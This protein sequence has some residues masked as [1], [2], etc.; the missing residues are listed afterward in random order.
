MEREG[1][2][3]FLE[4]KMRLSVFTDAVRDLSRLMSAIDLAALILQV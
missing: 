1:F 3:F 2:F 4:I